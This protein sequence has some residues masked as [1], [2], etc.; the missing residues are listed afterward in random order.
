MPAFILLLL[1]NSLATPCFICWLGWRSKVVSHLSTCYFLLK[2]TSFMFTEPHRPM[3]VVFKVWSLNI[4]QKQI[5]RTNPRT[6]WTRSPGW[7]PE[8][9]NNPS[10]WLWSTCKFQNIRDSKNR[11][12]KFYHSLLIYLKGFL[13]KI[14]SPINQVILNGNLW[15]KGRITVSLFSFN[16]PFSVLVVPSLLPRTIICFCLF[17]VGWVFKLSL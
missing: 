15:I 11:V 12:F 14:L 8:L 5:L 9:F 6:Y 13:C 3:Q 17:S 2:I 7:G 1:Q 4:L 10:R 16:C